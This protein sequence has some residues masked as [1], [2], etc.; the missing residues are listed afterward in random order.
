MEERSLDRVQELKR[1]EDSSDM[2]FNAVAKGVHTG[3]GEVVGAGCMRAQNQ[4]LD[5]PE[6]KL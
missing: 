6:R 4:H 5:F 2:L 3:R 1:C